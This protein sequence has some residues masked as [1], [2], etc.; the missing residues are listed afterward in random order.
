MRKIFRNKNLR[1]MD[2]SA[3]TGNGPFGV[4]TEMCGFGGFPPFFP[5]LWLAAWGGERNPPPP[6]KRSPADA[7]GFRGTNALLGRG[8]ALCFF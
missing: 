6:K 4:N 2:Y 3:G 5:V 1:P 7:A 8:R